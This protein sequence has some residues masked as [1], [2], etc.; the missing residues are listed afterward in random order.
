MFVINVGNLRKALK[1]V[2]HCEFGST[3]HHNN[4]RTCNWNVWCYVSA[5][6]L[7]SL[8]LVST[9]IIASFKTSIETENVTEN[10]YKPEPLCF[11]LQTFIKIH[12]YV[13]KNV[14][15]TIESYYKQ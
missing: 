15:W 12:L 3:N 8:S 14:S 5:L 9:S 2:L 4:V 13:K 6:I 11:L 10:H 7:T 1:C